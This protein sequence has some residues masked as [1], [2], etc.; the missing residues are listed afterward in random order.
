MIRATV[1]TGLTVLSNGDLIEKT[2]LP[3]GRTC[4]HYVLDFPHAP[5]LV[6]LVCG[7]FTEIKDRAP[8]TG[9]DVYYYAPKGREQD[10]QF[11]ESILLH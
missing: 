8:E 6:T 2:D 4:W 5:Y 3:D 9:V 1:T 11:H 10:T 7:A